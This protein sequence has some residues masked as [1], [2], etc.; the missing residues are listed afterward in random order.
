MIL[1]AYYLE[2]Y[3]AHFVLALYIHRDQQQFV[4]VFHVYC[5]VVLHAFCVFHHLHHFHRRFLVYVAIKFININIIK[6][7][8]LK[9]KIRKTQQVIFKIEKKKKNDK[10]KFYIYFFF[11]EN[12]LCEYLFE[13]VLSIKQRL[14][15]ILS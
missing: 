11:L 9:N 5:V 13:F 15:L 3:I 12:K 2:L 14:L 10:L 1:Q 6:Q 8:N 4:V 7:F